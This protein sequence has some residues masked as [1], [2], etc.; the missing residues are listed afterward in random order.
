[1]PID[2]EI[3]THEEKIRI[4]EAGMLTLMKQDF[5]IVKKFFTWFMGHLNPDDE[6]IDENDPAITV[7]IPALTR[8]LKR[9]KSIE[10]GSKADIGNQTIVTPLRI[11]GKLV[12][13]DSTVIAK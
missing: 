6:D 11:I 9:F 10:K 12:S 2:S 1:M 7:C 13:E 5:A 3:N 4:F 8:M